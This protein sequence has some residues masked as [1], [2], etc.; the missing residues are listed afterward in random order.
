MIPEPVIRTATPADEPALYALWARCFGDAPHLPALY[1]LDDGRHHRTFVAAGPDGAL[2]AVVVYVPRTVRDVH[3]VPHR[4]GGIGSVATRP[5][6]RGRGLV[7]ALLA[8]ATATMSGEG[9]GWSLLFTGTPGVYESSGWRT[10]A[11]PHAEGPLAAAPEAPG[12][13]REA[14]SVDRAPLARLQEAHNAHRPLSSVRSA[15]D[16]RVRVPAWYGAD[17]L[18][19]VA[20]D[21]AGGLRGWLV[22]RIADG[23][24]EVLEA[25]VAADDCLGT[26]YAALAV[27]ARA[28]G[29]VRARTAVPASPGAEHAL[30]RLLRSG[31]VTRGTDTTGMY[32]PLLTPARTVERTVA[33]P[34]AAYWYGDSF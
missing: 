10:F 9:C 4:I 16:W 8:E 2:D 23:T 12:G 11:R 22:A 24:A 28:A 26:L 5:E 20:E 25:A 1:A 7:R 17:T 27:R 6:A 34:G 19:L 30:P 13:V 29:A 14:R 33:A 18:Q 3:G 15:D 32:R 31:A 21:G